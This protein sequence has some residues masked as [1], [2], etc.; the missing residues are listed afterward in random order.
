M[1]HDM[2]DEHIHWTE[3]TDN[4]KKSGFGKFAALAYNAVRTCR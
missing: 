1:P 2:P 3:P 4:K